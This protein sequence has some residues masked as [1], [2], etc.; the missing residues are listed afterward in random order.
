[1]LSEPETPFDPDAAYERF[2]R[3][4]IILGDAITDGETHTFGR[5]H[6][7]VGFVIGETETGGR[8]HIPCWRVRTGN[9]EEAAI[10]K[11]SAVILGFGPTPR[12]WEEETDAR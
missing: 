4:E 6:T 3:G 2:L 1:M 9:G 11:E 10:P 12:E 7:P 8:L 5:I